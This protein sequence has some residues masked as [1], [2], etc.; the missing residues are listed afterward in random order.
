MQPEFDTANRREVLYVEDHPVNVHLMEALFKR[1]PHLRL[2]VAEDGLT[3][4]RIAPTLNPC[5][6]L[7]DLRLPDCHGCALLP[8][9]RRLDG[10]ADIPAVAVTAE[11]GFDAA[12]TG[13]CEVWPKPLELGFV[14][15]RLVHWTAPPVEARSRRQETMSQPSLGMLQHSFVK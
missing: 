10:W 6:L 4:R 14:L 12:G 13:F 1:L 8:Q 5:L 7:L 11:P 3:A 9:L 2:V 15:A